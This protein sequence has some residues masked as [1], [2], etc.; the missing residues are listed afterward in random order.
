MLSP[1]LVIDINQAA[2]AVDAKQIEQ[3]ITQIPNTQQH[4]AQTIAT[5]LSEYDF[6]GII[7]LT[8]A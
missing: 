8:E 5:M 7:E 6:D 3:L 4:I 1:T 2:I